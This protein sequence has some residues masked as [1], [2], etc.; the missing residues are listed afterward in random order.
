MQPAPDAIGEFKVVTNNMSAEY[1]RAAGATINVN[2]RS[3]TNALHGSG[4][5]FLRDTSMN[6]TGF[7]KPATGKPT[8]DRNQFG[9]VLGGPI[10]KNKA[11]FFGDYEGLRQTRKVTG[12]S[13]IAT[14]AQRQGILPVDVRDPRTGVVYPAGTP[15]PM[16]ALRAQGALGAARH[17][18]RRQR[19]QLHARCRSSPP[20]PNKAGGKID[21]QAEPGALDVR[22]LR[23]PQPDDRR[24][25]EHPAAVRRRRQ[26]PH[27]RAQPAARARLDLG[28]DARRRCS[29]RGSA[30]RGRRPARTRRRSAPTARSMQFGLPGPADRRAASPAACRRR[31]SPATRTSG[32]RRPTRSGSIRPSTTRRSTTPGR[33]GA[34]SF[35][36]GYEFQ[37]IDTRSAGREPALRPRHL[38]RPVHAVRPAPPSSNLYNLADFMLG[39]RAQYALSSVLVAD[40]RRNMHF[41]YVQ[42]DWR[43]GSK[44][45]LNLGLRYEYSTP[46]WESE[47]RP[48]ELRSGD[49]LDDP[50]EGRLDLRPRAD[51]SRPQQLRAAARI[52]LHADAGDG[53]SAAATASATCTSAAPAA[54]TSCRSTARR[55]S[56]RSSTRPSRRRRRSCRRSRAIRRAS[57]IRRSSTR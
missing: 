33:R 9:G 28:A 43:V 25:A 31:S 2:Y 42:D 13:T 54:A 3:G 23:L 24:S 1:G 51:Q 10:V 32:V 37:R 26:R 18:R 50:G 20:I 53:R 14:P 15:I 46:Y 27:L 45:T 12:F 7:F 5:E 39:L 21:V 44:L 22:P 8:L 6:A 41:A 55:S 29:K 36:S 30:T 38:Q 34:H 52:R 48:L 17:E 56:T 16:T 47:Q 57:P 40:L 49:Q 19:Q 11:F 35:K 4:W